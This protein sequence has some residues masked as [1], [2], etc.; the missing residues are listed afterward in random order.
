[1]GRVIAGQ[2]HNPWVE[3]YRNL[4]FQAKLQFTLIA[5]NE[6]NIFRNSIIWAFSLKVGLIRTPQKRGCQNLSMMA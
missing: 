6:S 2:F 3:I 5:F 4:R 1:V